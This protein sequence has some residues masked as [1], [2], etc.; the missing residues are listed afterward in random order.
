MSAVAPRWDIPSAEALQ[1]LVADPLPLGLRAGPARRSFLRDLYFDTP[2]GDLRR[3]DVACR[4]CFAADDRRTLVLEGLRPGPPEAAEV[5]ELDAAA[6]F[7]GK[8]GPARRLRALIDPARLVPSVELETER[9]LR[10]VRRALVPWPELELVLDVVTVRSSEAAPVFRELT[11][12]PRPWGTIGV[13]RLGAAL[14][15]R[16][17]LHPLATDRRARAD[18]LLAALETEALARAVQGQR[19]V[20]IVAVADGRMAFRRKGGGLQLL[21]VEGGGEEACRRAL[22][23]LLGTAEGQVR[24]LGTV[25]ATER[26]PVLEVWVARRL[27]RDLTTASRPLQW[28]TPRDIVGRVGSPVLREPKTLAALAVAARSP[29]VPEWSGS[30][31]GGAVGESAAAVEPFPEADEADR[32]SRVTLSELRVPVLPAAALDAERG[33]PEQ[34]LNAQLSWLEFN[35][36]VLA[37]AEDPRTPFR[38]RLRFLAIFSTNLDQFFMVEVASL[39][40]AVAAG[41]TPRSADGLTPQEE[42]DAIA[43]RLRPLVERQ[44]RCFQLLRAGELAGAGVSIR[45]FGELDAAAQG[46]LR[47]WFGDQV[48]PLLTPKALTRAPGHPFPFIA[49]RRLSLAL[50][51][52]DTPTSPRHFVHLELPTS[53]PRFVPLPQDEG[54]VPLEEVIGGNLEALLPGRQV[55]EVHPF[56]ITRSGDIHLDETGAA[57]FAQAMEEEIRRRPFGPVVRVEVERAMPQAMRD[58]LQREFRFEESEQHSTLSAADFYEADGIVDLGALAELAPP[59]PTSDYRPVSPADPFPPGVPVCDALDR[60]D[61]LVHHPYD[62]FSTSFERWLDECADDP[63]VLAIKLTL[64]RPGGPSR[65]LEALHRAAGAG[66]D[67]SVLVEL[68]ARFDEEHNI[69][70]ARSLEQLGIHVVTGLVNLKTHA[71]IAL[72]VRRRGG[73]IRRYAHVGTGNYNPDTARVYSDLGLFTAEED[74]GADLNALFNE[75]TGSSRPPQAEFRRLLV[76]PTNMLRRFLDLIEREAEHARA[77]RGGRIRVKLNGLADGPVIAALY[78]A[79]QA[80]ASVE[81]VVRGI[82]MLRPGVP[83][84]SER[85]RVTSI[86]GRF[87]EH[88]RIYHFEN[89]GAAEYYIGSADWRPRN[90]RRRIEVAVP[91]RDAAARARLDRI[92]TTEL[93]DPTAWELAADGSYTRRTARPGD[94]ASA[95]EQFLEATPASY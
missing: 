48:L 31:V 45:R 76:A 94:G 72:V 1:A 69:A 29:L 52:R 54:V 12:R 92:L 8:S 18:E 67:V 14:A 60:K 20:A 24:L 7:A 80:G 53:L 5:A 68:K 16:H 61:V 90:L 37:L 62:S 95:Q 30:L 15:E 66:K 11:L 91:V 42:L 44:Y 23:Q 13:A 70:W 22:R 85:I 2:A 19:E 51:L 73:R 46:F 74:L 10:L 59:R 63:D 33:A 75:L 56:R 87:L 40:H 50:A 49:D 79:S 65:I 41:L 55:V 71:K 35:A 28:F 78:R 38:A 27:R 83:G 17:G 21:V 39:K 26:R 25:P 6:I 58:L 4:V 3:R 36:R 84:L 88:A 43:I 57:N 32:I 77:G 82:C 86:L 34:F 81:L 64:Y 9:R 93:A 47:R 89:G